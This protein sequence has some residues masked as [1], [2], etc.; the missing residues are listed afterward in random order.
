MRTGIHP[1]SK[2]GTCLRSKTP[3]KSYLLAAFAHLGAE[4]AID[5]FGK[6][7]RPLIHIGHAELNCPW[8]GGEQ[9]L[10]ER[11]L[12]EGDEVLQ[13]LFGKLVGVDLRHPLAAFLLAAGNPLGVDE[14]NFVAILLMVSFAL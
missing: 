14:A 2:C 4:F 10:A 12:V 8:L 9:F 13:L 7:L 6:N 3:W 5:G 1:T 11:R